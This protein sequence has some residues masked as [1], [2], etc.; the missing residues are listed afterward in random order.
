MFPLNKCFIYYC[1]F[2]HYL[3]NVASLGKTLSEARKNLNEIQSSRTRR[4]VDE[5]MHNSNV[6]VTAKVEAGLVPLMFK[7]GRGEIENGYINKPLINGHYYAFSV[8]SW[9]L[10]DKGVIFTDKIKILYIVITIVIISCCF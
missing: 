2:S 8:K 3:I 10:S 1:I 6:Y 9:V 4:T 5:S 7:V